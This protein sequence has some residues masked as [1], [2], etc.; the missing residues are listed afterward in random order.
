MSKAAIFDELEKPSLN[1]VN[2]ISVSLW[3]PWLLRAKRY[4]FTL[5]CL[6][7]KGVLQLGHILLLVT[8]ACQG[9]DN[10]DATELSGVFNS[11]ISG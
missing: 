6:A 11:D 10:S 3:A 8:L 2:G 4:S 5:P 7:T 1:K 9:R